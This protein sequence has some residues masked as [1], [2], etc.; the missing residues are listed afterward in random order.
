MFFRILSQYGKNCLTTEAAVEALKIDSNELPGQ[1]Y[2]ADR[3]CEIMHGSGYES[4]LFFFSK[5][6]SKID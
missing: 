3:Q 4:V 1:R 6:S 2:S 5:F